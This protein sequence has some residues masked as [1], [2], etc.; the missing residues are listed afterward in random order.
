MNQKTEKTTIIEVYDPVMC[1]STG[2]CGPDVD[3]TLADFAN[4]VKWLKSQGV[5]VKRFN[6]GQ[7]PEAFKANS[8]VLARLRQAGTEALPIILVNG[9]MMSEGGYPDRAAL[10]QWSGLNLTNGAASH[11]GKADTAQPETLYNNKTE[12]LVALGAAVASGSESVLR[13]MFARGEELGLSTEDMSRAMQTGLNVRQT[14][15]SDVVKTANELLGITSNG[16]APG[17]GCC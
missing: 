4:D 9:E 1:C 3:D 17:S 6:L 13:N 10:I 16:C 7:E 11:T 12:I 14:P 8:Q 5:D 2:V 15:L